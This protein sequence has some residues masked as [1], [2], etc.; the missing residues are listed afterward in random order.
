[1]DHADEGIA[2]ELFTASLEAAAFRQR[3]VMALGDCGA[4]A[5][6]LAGLPG[7]VEASLRIPAPRPGH[8][9]MK[10]RNLKILNHAYFPLLNENISEI[11]MGFQNPRDAARGTPDG[12]G[13]GN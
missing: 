12:G 7:G 3:G 9:R 1:M 4:S 11:R 2:A 5:R 13:R 8:R 6:A 10:S